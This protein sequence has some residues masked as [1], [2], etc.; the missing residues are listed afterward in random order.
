MKRK[1]PPLNG[2]DAAELRRHLLAPKSIAVIGASDDPKKLSGRTL[3]F[4]KRFGYKGRLLPVNPKRAVVQG[5]PAY[6]SLDDIEED[7]DLALLSVTAEATLPALRDCARR[8]VRVAVAFAAGFAETGAAG[9]RRERE[10]AELCAET[11]LRVLG[12]NCLG[13]I[14]VEDRVTATF[15]SAM[16]EDCEL[17]SGPAAFVSQSGAFGTFLFSAA[18]QT[19]VGFRYF[20]ST[21]NETD[22]TAGELLGA[23]AEA[24]DV[25]VLLAY[26][27]GVC[28]GPALVRAA[29]RA[30]E[31][32][33][34]LVVV[35]AGATPDGARA[36]A[37]HTASAPVD[38]AVFDAVTGAHGVIRVDGIEP[39][40]DMARVLAD[41]RR[42][43]GRRLSILTVSGGVA[44]VMTDRAVQ[45]GLAVD[46]WDARWRAAMAEVIPPFG[47]PRNPV[48]LTASIITD[49]DLLARALHVVA[50]HP[51]TDM[52]AVLLGNSGYGADQLIRTLHR[53][54][55][56]TDRPF[57]VAWTGGNE[58]PRRQLATL[59]VPVFTDPGRAA[60]AL[61][62]LADH[63]LRTPVA[64]PLP[65]RESAA[66][67]AAREIIAAARSAGHGSLGAPES[68]R[69][70]TAYGLAVPAVESDTP[71]D[72]VQ[73]VL[74]FRTDD[75]FGPLLWACRDDGGPGPADRALS[76]PLGC[77]EDACR[78]LRGV[79]G[80]ESAGESAL[81][82]GAEALTRL[83]LLAAELVGDVE[84][85]ALN[86]ARTGA[87]RLADGIV[88]NSGC[89]SDAFTS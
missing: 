44:A 28:D 69:V 86:V 75:T 71:P 21:G 36:A 23:L 4:L 20:V 18:Q 65:Q 2:P 19:G 51:D 41:G 3:D 73:L 1:R 68:A 81:R 7:I 15:A 48:D 11:G 5:L 83:S 47:S 53:E 31:L 37:W 33:K 22:L 14:A 80:G 52:V 42:P 62:R 59:G 38:D 70:L 10:I 17:L 88:I 29:R 30:T 58:E 57:V 13:L 40:I 72:G 54:Y 50:Q 60:A 63:A 49:Q 84:G 25:R 9:A 61:A 27:E 55:Q 35:K 66:A 43:R 87:V 24:D 16:D 64:A 45:A 8:G 39:L 78:F 82:A 12:P 76:V 26:L 79:P 89:G 46:E 85:L 32:D 6:R 74:G 34:P 67:R 56:A 77:P